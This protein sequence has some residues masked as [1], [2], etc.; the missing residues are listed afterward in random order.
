MH[1]EVWQ[2]AIVSFRHLEKHVFNYYELP[3]SLGVKLCDKGEELLSLNFT[4]RPLKIY[5][6]VLRGIVHNI[7]W[8][9]K[10][11][12]YPNPNGSQANKTFLASLMSINTEPFQRTNI[13]MKPL[14]PPFWK[15][16]IAG[17]SKQKVRKQ[18]ISRKNTRR[19]R[20]QQ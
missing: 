13:S 5:N 20:V 12:F 16:F 7:N 2:S 3:R 18:D 4:I 10:E 17:F 11:N 15:C 14:G 8:W 6:I 9:I 19:T 1:Y